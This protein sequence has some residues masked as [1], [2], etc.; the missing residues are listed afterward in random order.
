MT[1]L[2][3]TAVLALF[4]WQSAQTP[5][6]AGQQAPPNAPRGQGQG[7]GRGQGGGG[8]RGAPIAFE[9][10]TGFK[11]IFDGTTLKNWDG[12]PQFWRAEGGAI[13]GQSTPEKQ[14]A[15]NT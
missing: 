9:D 10:R 6:P 13:V 2:L 8:G 11:Q 5:P 15:Q 4:M 3:S 7:Q 14:V 12:D 1:K